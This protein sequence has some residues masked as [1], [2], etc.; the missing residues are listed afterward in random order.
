VIA[1]AEPVAFVLALVLL[2][3]LAGLF[4]AAV[5]LALAGPFI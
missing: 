1:R 3:S 2:L 5:F 4:A